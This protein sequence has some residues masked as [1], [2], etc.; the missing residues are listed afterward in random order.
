MPAPDLSAARVTDSQA[1]AYASVF[2]SVS[3]LPLLHSGGVQDLVWAGGAAGFLLYVLVEITEPVSEAEW[4][5]T[6]AM[7]RSVAPFAGRKAALPSQ[8]EG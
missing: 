4:R 5:D 1:L 7:A 6:V 3:M 8:R 2:V